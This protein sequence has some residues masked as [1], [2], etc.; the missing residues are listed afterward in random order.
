[1]S[2][3]VQPW[4]VVTFILI[5]HTRSY[6]V[7]TTGLDLLHALAEPST[8]LSTRLFLLRSVQ[9]RAQMQYAMPIC[10]LPNATSHTSL[11]LPSSHLSCSLPGIRPPH[12]VSSLPRDLSSLK[13]LD[14]CGCSGIILFFQCRRKESCLNPGR[15][16][17]QRGNLRCRGN[18]IRI[19]CWYS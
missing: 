16:R 1:M 18:K 19:G 6:S 9:D 10:N 5:I 17:V 15:L 8:S 12:N 4:C 3:L 2:Y 13:G 7:I 11:Y 14:H